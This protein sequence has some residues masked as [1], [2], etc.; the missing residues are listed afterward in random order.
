MMRAMAV[1][2]ILAALW[3]RTAGTEKHAPVFPAGTPTVY[4]EQNYSQ[5]DDCLVC[6]APFE[7]FTYP[8]WCG[9]LLAGLNRTLTPVRCH[10]QV[11]TWPCCSF[12][13]RPTCIG[14]RCPF[15]CGSTYHRKTPKPSRLQAQ[16]AVG[17]RRRLRLLPCRSPG[18][19]WG[20]DHKCALATLFRPKVARSSSRIWSSSRN[21]LRFS[22]LS[23]VPCAKGKK[24]P[25]GVYYS[26]KVS[27]TLGMC[28]QRTGFR[29]SLSIGTRTLHQT[30]ASA[31]HLCTTSLSRPHHQ[32]C[33][34]ILSI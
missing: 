11:G 23:S 26:C 29:C 19:E 18:S 17:P 1:M 3:P 12:S 31:Y 6:F 8:D 7:S 27:A 2:F 5:L 21:K 14:S 20:T 9:E 30:T 4:K 34:C 32:R 13:P 15:T 25:I 33:L 24:T 10:V 16:V 28:L 22:L